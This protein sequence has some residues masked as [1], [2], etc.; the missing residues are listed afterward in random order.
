MAGLIKS[1]HK[2]KI[3]NNTNYEDEIKYSK[4]IKYDLISIN[5]TKIFIIILFLLLILTSFHAYISYL[6]FV[7]I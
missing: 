2:N 5:F 6:L 1:S 4:K 7:I 3:L